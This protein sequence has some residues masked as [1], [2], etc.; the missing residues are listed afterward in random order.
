MKPWVTQSQLR[1]RV[2]LALQRASQVV[3][4]PRLLG[5]NREDVRLWFTGLGEAFE[6]HH[7]DQYP[8]DYKAKIQA[9]WPQPSPHTSV[10]NPRE[11]APSVL[12]VPTAEIEEFLEKV[13]GRYVKTLK[14]EWWG[15]LSESW[16]QQGVEPLSTGEFNRLLGE[17]PFSR[18]L[19]PLREQ[20][21]LPEGLSAAPLKGPFK[22]LALFSTVLSQYDSARSAARGSKK[23]RLFKIDLTPL[24]DCELH[25][26]QELAGSIT[27][28]EQKPNGRYQALAIAF[29]RTGVVL[30]PSHG[31]RWKLAQYLVLQGCANALIALMHP[32]LHF[33][34]D[35]I[36]AVTKTLLPAD[37]PVS[38]LI[39]P[40]C[41]L[42]LPLNFAVLYIDRSVAHNHQKEIYTPFPMT[43]DGFLNL[44]KAGYGGIDDNSAYPSFRFEKGG[45]KIPSIYGDYLNSSY[46][47]LRDFCQEVL[48]ASG[49]NPS[50]KLLGTWADSIASFLDGFPNAREIQE[51]GTLGDVIATFIHT[52]SFAHSADHIAY[53]KESL[54]KVPLRIRVPPPSLGGSFVLDRKKLL[55]KTDLFRHRMAWRMYFRANTLRRFT[56][57]TYSFKSGRA[58]LALDR[59]RARFQTWDRGTL[60][61]RFATLDQIACSIQ[62]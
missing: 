53:A 43:R 11:L 42:Q 14:N 35:T 31:D 50:E 59:M 21:V 17:T 46:E 61:Q 56:E 58:L 55:R 44:M 30:T 54:R 41:Y 20:E 32:R 19:T 40:H 33:P 29:P 4:L 34:S 1:E 7:L 10:Q 26:G 5:A 22:D 24:D 15:A 36:N 9:P 52:V 28:L 57:V 23:G 38:Q 6:G 51:K 47:I 60:P 8:K 62:Y 2:E 16:L 39:L 37:H 48:D 27:L 13:V 18:F 3:Q 45:Q 49:V 25:P 12:H